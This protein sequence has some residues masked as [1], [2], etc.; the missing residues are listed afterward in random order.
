MQ[1]DPIEP[2]HQFAVAPAFDGVGEAPFMELDIE[3]LDRVID[4]CLEAAGAGGGA[5][6]HHLAKGGVRSDFERLGADGP[7]QAV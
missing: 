6:L 3:V 5:G 2:S 7:G 1:G 4:P